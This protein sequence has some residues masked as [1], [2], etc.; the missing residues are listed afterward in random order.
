MVY[1]HNEMLMYVVLGY[2]AD[3]DGARQRVGQTSSGWSDRRTQKTDAE[4]RAWL[5]FQH[6]PLLLCQLHNFYFSL[7]LRTC[8]CSNQTAWRKANLASKLSIDNMEKQALLN[9]T[10]SAVRQRWADSQCSLVERSNCVV[11]LWTLG[12][13]LVLS[14]PLCVPPIK[15]LFF[16]LLFLQLL[17]G[18]WLK[19]AWPRQQA[20]SQRIS[21][22]SA[23]WW[24]SKFNKVRTLQQH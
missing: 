5:F 18:I 17:S 23:E 2:G 24:R 8:H 9:G 1:C 16:I 15:S 4:V 13:E 12:V 22:A 21:W 20:V 10:D 7:G 14:K 19:K 11:S 6:V 3:G